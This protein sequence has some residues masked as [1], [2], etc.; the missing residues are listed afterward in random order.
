LKTGHN[1]HSLRYFFF[2]GDTHSERSR[3]FLKTRD[4]GTGGSERGV[5]GMS[6]S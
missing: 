6:A 3:H 4:L 5:A 2:K 1:I